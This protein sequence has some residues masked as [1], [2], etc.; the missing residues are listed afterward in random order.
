MAV[1]DCCRHKLGTRIQPTKGAGDSGLKTKK[2]H[3][4]LIIFFACPPGGDSNGDS[5]LTGD[6]LNKLHSCVD[7][8]NSLVLP[9]KLIDWN[10]PNEGE[11]M[12][13]ADS[14]II[15]KNVFLPEISITSDHLEEEKMPEPAAISD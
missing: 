7:A 11:M 15:L 1:L 13:E 5:G 14:K 2:N 4:N 10:M 6:I 3:R 9:G 8:D 12:I